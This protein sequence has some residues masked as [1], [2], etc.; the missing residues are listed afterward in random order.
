[1]K[2][3]TI[4]G[5]GY[6]GIPY[7][8]L[9]SVDHNVIIYDINKSKIDKI[10][11]GINPVTDNNVKGFPMFSD[12]DISA[13]TDASEAFI[14]ADIVIIA[15]PTNYDEQK[16]CFDTTSIEKTISS[17]LEVKKDVLIVIKSTVPVGYTE[18]IKKKFDYNNIFFSPEFLREGQALKDV[19]NPSRIV[20]G[21]DKKQAKELIHIFKNSTVNK[22][23]P[24][25]KTGSS[26]AEF[27]KLS[28]NTFL[29]IRISFFNEIAKYACENGLDAREIINIIC[30]DN[31]IG[32]YY[33]NPS[34]GYGGYC[35]PKDTKQLY[36]NFEGLISPL[37][38]ASIDSNNRHIDFVA[39]KLIKMRPQRVGI[40]KLAMKKGS[41]NYRSSSIIKVIKILKEYNIPLVIYEPVI[42]DGKFEGIDVVNNVDEFINQSTVIA[43]NRMD[44]TMTELKRKDE[45]KVFSLD[46]YGDDV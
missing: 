45:K 20:I 41:D 33:N 40:Y 23:V 27:A 25:Y 12:L 22:S 26:E 46:L 14:E 37:V 38:R 44:S 19:L 31:R 5:A 2:N 9:F 11:I 17:I 36:S 13:T 24:T 43:I 34:F 3:I 28:S 42:T 15:T 32:D 8:Q 35:L 7:A 10:K 30:S 1:V 6:V 18:L 39:H 21:G 29:A 4:V 16:D